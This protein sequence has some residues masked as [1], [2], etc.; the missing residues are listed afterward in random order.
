MAAQSTRSPFHPYSLLSGTPYASYDWL[1]IT[2]ARNRSE[3]LWTCSFIGKMSN[4]FP[5]AFISAY[6]VV[7]VIIHLSTRTSM[8]IKQGLSLFIFG[9]K[10]GTAEVRIKRVDFS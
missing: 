10:K 9:W 1:S 6:A 8:S 5:V 2:W 4:S 7:L 3:A